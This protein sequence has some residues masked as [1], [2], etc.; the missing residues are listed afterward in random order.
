VVS[1]DLRHFDERRPITTRHDVLLTRRVLAWIVLRSQRS[2][3]AAGAG[4]LAADFA[5]NLPEN[6]SAFTRS[7]IFWA[8][9]LRYPRMGPRSDAEWG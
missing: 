8:W 1:V 6:K 3:I 2:A 7:A 4:L 5:S 9:R